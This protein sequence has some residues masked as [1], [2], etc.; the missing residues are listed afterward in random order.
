MSVSDY[1]TVVVKAGLVLRGAHGQWVSLR[2][3]MIHWDNGAVTR[4]FSDD[5]SVSVFLTHLHELQFLRI[6]VGATARGTYMRLS[7]DFWQR[8]AQLAD[9]LRND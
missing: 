9:D 1:L 7:D 5:A 8:F 6:S 3:F 4:A 2:G